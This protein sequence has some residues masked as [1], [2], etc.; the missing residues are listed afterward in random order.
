LEGDVTRGCRK[1]TVNFL[2]DK[3]GL[4]KDVGGYAPITTFLPEGIALDKGACW[5]D[6]EGVKRSF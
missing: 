2:S 4:D 3:M 5:L 1:V 6:E